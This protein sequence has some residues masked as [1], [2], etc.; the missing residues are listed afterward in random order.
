[1]SKLEIVLSNNQ[2]ELI[3]NVLIILAKNETIPQRNCQKQN[4]ENFE[5]SKK[6]H[7]DDFLYLGHC[8]STSFLNVIIIANSPPCSAAMFTF[9]VYIFS[10]FGGAGNTLYIGGWHLNI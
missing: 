6:I 10:H 8:M 3:F 9:N 7:K 1:M 5:R 2:D 4:V